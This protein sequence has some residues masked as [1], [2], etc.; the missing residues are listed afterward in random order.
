MPVDRARMTCA[1]SAGFGTRKGSSA[2]MSVLKSAS[3]RLLAISYNK[4]KSNGLERPL[5]LRKN[6]IPERKTFV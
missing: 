3:M 2:G 6:S 5:R 4:Q 1:G